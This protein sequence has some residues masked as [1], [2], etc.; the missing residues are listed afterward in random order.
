[1][2]L[3]QDRLAVQFQ[4]FDLVTLEQADDDFDTR[5]LPVRDLVF[6]PIALTRPRHDGQLQI[7]GRPN[8]IDI[9]KHQAGRHAVVTSPPARSGSRGT[10]ARRSRPRPAPS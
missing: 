3:A 4:F 8:P 2:A 10:S 5:P 1:M 9:R 7:A 6:K